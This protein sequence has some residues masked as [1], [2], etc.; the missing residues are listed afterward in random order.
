MH[1]CS[2]M[3]G[4][5]RDRQNNV[6]ENKHKNLIFPALKAFANTNVQYNSNARSHIFNIN[7]YNSRWTKCEKSFF[8]ES[9]ECV[10]DIHDITNYDFVMYIYFFLLS[11]IHSLALFCFK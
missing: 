9:R 11:L 6:M 5:A 3:V 10:C 8:S 1:A 2:V 4:M 7:I